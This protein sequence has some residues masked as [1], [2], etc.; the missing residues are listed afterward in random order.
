MAGSVVM[1]WQG[2][3]CNY[4]LTKLTNGRHV[5]VG[6]KRELIKEVRLFVLDAQEFRQDWEANGPMVP[7]LDPMEAVDRLKKFQLM[8]E[9]RF[10]AIQ[11][12]MCCI[13]ASPITA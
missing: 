3:S 5:Q 2:P 9:V 13:K 6:F 10:E 12:Y 7:G 4:K 8:F 11:H 1:Q